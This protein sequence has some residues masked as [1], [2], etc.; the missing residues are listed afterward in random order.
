MKIKLSRETETK[1]MDAK[2]ICIFRY[3]SWSRQSQ[4]VLLIGI[5]VR[6][7]VLYFVEVIVLVATQ[8]KDK[9]F[10]I[11]FESEGRCLY[12]KKKKKSCLAF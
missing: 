3:I 4:S 6:T 11:L 2:L 12:Q 5:S 7:D 1:N 9:V 8:E 10:A